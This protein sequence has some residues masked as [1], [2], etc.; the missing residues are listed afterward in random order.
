MSVDPVS[1]FCIFNFGYDPGTQ[2]E[3]LNV[4]LGGV[5]VIITSET[6]VCAQWN[7]TQP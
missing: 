6:C 7:I 3:S 5:L 1:N 4:C 2:E